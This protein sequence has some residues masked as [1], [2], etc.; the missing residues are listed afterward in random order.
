MRAVNLLPP[1]LRSRIAGEGDPRVAYGVVGGLAL[2]LAMVV[3][4]ISYSNKAATLQEQAASIQA[5]ADRARTQNVKP[6]QSFNDFAGVAQSRT[7]LVGG[8]A[9]AR[10]P[11]GNALYNL[12]RSLPE[13]VTLNDIK[14]VT[15]DASVAATNQA[16]GGTAVSSTAKPTLALSG[17]TSGWIGFSRLMVWLREMPGVERVN[18]TQTTNDGQASAEDQSEEAKRKQNCGP[19]PLSFSLT[20]IYKERQVDLIGLPKVASATPA[21]GAT[22]ATGGTAA[23]GSPEPA[24]Q[25]TPAPEG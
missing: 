23:A 7:L 18:A 17:C 4:A 25:T 2:L 13:D 19:A 12:S 5:Q 15:A 8:L 11:W 21:A 16:T 1:E 6:V 3:L 14:A 10:F 20:V 24:A 9:A 22:G